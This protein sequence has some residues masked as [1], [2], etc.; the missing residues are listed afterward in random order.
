[1]DT[2]ELTPLTLNDDNQALWTAVPVALRELVTNHIR[3]DSAHGACDVNN[4]TILTA[5]LKPSIRAKILDKADPLEI[6]KAA[7]KIKE[8]KMDKKTAKSLA[9]VSQDEDVNAV[10]PYNNS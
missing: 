2:I 8:L 10:R 9:P 7:C 1:M 4:S 6:K 5:G 3:R